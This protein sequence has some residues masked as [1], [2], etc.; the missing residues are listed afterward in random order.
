[1][2]SRP[3]RTFIFSIPGELHLIGRLR[4]NTPSEFRAFFD[5]SESL[6]GK[7]LEAD[8]FYMQPD[9]RAV[10]S[11]ALERMKRIALVI[12]HAARMGRKAI[13]KKNKAE[14]EACA[15]RI[16]DFKAEM[17]SEPDRYRGE[18]MLKNMSEAGKAKAAPSKKKH[19]DWQHQADEIWQE[20]P[21]ASIRQVAEL[22]SKKTGDN[23]NTIRGVIKKNKKQRKTRS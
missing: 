9:R 3:S 8:E 11:E 12:Q 2:Q 13:N 17:F 4:L 19:A 7:I 15:Y 14:A 10:R 5:E 22:I 1:M 16:L 18:S 23:F 21:K 6:A 20:R